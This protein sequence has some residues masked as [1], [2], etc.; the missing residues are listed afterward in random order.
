MANRP[1]RG[2]RVAKPRYR[3]KTE[4][5]VYATMRDG[6]RI[7]LRIYRPDAEG[8]FPVLFA[9]SPYM[10]ATDD[11]P[12][13]P[14]FLWRE[15]GPVPW[16][17]EQH[18]YVYVHA[19][20]RGTGTS[21]GTYR[22]FDT[23][24]QNDLY[25][26]VE[27]CG[28]APW[29]NGKVGGIGQSYY[30]WSQ[31]FM[32][33]VNPPSLACIAPYDGAVDIYR[34][35]TYHGGTYCDFMAWW[36]QH[37]RVNNLHRAA[38]GPG[39]A[40]LSADLGWQ[41]A[42]HQ[43]YDAFWRERS[44][45]ERLG[46]IKVPT[47]SIGHWGKMALHLRGNIIGYEDVK[48]P[49]KLIVTGA[50]DVFEAH[51]L[52]DHVEFHEAELLPFYDRY[53]KGTSN[54]W[55]KRAPVKLYARGAEQ[56]HEEAEW[57]LK[58]AKSVSYYLRKGPSKS[59]TSLNDGGLSTEPP[60]RNEGATSYR[61][62]D[63]QW[64]FGVVSMGKFGP[65]PIARVL[66]FTTA[67]LTE[68]VEVT[69]PIV[70]ELFAASSC[71]D[72]DFIV[73]LADQLPQG[74]DDRKAGKQPGSVNVSKGWLRASHREKDEKRSKPYRPVY[75][76]MN[77]QPIEPGK[78]YRYEVEVMPCSHVF[79]AGHRIRLE[80]ANADSMFTD[81]FFAHQYM[82][83]KVGRDTIEHGAANASRLILPIVPAR[84]K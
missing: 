19:D 10:Y 82:P 81:S 58:R 1:K 17:V 32:G 53:L 31:W 35:C 84:K 28:R 2:A 29:S 63:P 64:K 16:Y 8:Q 76:H 23:A 65:D 36:Y 33:V 39:G 71:T 40:A 59:V 67:P 44:A 7:G 34:D 57:P 77:P 50:K 5:G 80:I 60:R 30:A 26:L 73:K 4:S 46:D 14:L 22:F 18:G 11:L 45:W 41:F 24:E 78:T 20:V 6:T 3:M 62:P 9:A 15:V 69:G 12:H 25:D 68:D 49:K 54:G 70:L 72:T 21:D 56:W 61:Y 83:Y 52:F 51:D 75:T 47:L 66:T 55:E 43:T 27:W 79:K 42:R 38:S 37:V 48:A 13:S 74:A